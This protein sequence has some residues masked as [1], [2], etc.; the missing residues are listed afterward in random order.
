M[1]DRKS[2]DLWL[3]GKIRTRTSSTAG[4]STSD[5]IFYLLNWR[6][7][8]SDA[9]Y[10]PIDIILY[11]KSKQVEY[12][13]DK[14]WRKVWLSVTRFP[15]AFSPTERQPLSSADKVHCVL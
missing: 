15:I 3:T 13:M 1:I 14:E 8:R 6:S 2:N 7:W 10:S 5:R 9:E 11:S 4:T 12:M